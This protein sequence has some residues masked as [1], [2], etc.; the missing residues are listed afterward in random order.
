MHYFA[1]VLIE[2]D[3][4]DEIEEAVAKALAPYDENVPVAPYKRYIE[5]KD[6]RYYPDA[7][8]TT[9]DFQL[10]S[11]Y[12][13]TTDLQELASK[14][15]QWNGSRGGVD[16]D[17]LYYVSK[18]NQNS[19][20]DWYEIGGR[21]NNALIIEADFGRTETNACFVREISPESRL[22]YII[23]T[24]D[25]FS[26]TKRTWEEKLGAFGE[27]AAKSNAAWEGEARAILS[28]F[29]NCLAVVVDMHI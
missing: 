24:P 20:W 27:N 23:I 5:D 10:M 19:L 17:G 14:M 6:E 9:N 15:Q 2:P 29:P 4:E 8:Y 3:S 18:Y 22:P 16:E 7:D 13:G 11:K 21:W 12:Y 25:G 26:H 28:E 1:Y